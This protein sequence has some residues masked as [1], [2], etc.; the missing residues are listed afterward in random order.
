MIVGFGETHL[1]LCLLGRVS[2]HLRHLRGVCV[3]GDALLV[4]GEVKDEGG[5]VCN[6]EAEIV[7]GGGC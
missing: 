7:E 1:R 4:E 6:P 5:V 2:S 3:L